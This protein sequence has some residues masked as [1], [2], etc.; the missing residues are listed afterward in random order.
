MFKP[1][2]EEPLFHP[3]DKN[4]IDFLPEVLEENNKKDIVK[5]NK[6]VIELDNEIDETSSL[7]NFFE[8]MKQISSDKNLTLFDDA[9]EV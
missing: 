5:E 3:D 7:A 6:S 9:K 4:K 1:E 8:D 2:K